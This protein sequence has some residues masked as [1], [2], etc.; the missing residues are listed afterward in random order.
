MSND[1]NR[2]DFLKR[3]V[4]G[5]AIIAAS[6]LP[7]IAEDRPELFPNRGGYERLA[8][9][10]ATVHIGLPKPFSILHI[11]DSHLTAA[12]P[13]ES[14]RMQRRHKSRTAT[15]G[16]R[17]EE[18]LRDSLAWARDHVDYIVYTGDLIDWQTE[19]N[20]D[21]VRKYFGDNMFGAIGN[22][23]HW[24]EEWLTDPSEQDKAEFREANHRALSEVYPFDVECHAQ[25]IGGVNFIAMDNAFG[26]FATR[27]VE[28]FKAEAAKGFPMVLCMHVPL[29]SDDIWRASDRFW[30]EGNMTVDPSRLGDEYR[31]QRED[32]VTR[33]FIA[34]LRQEPLLRAL[35]TGHEHFALDDP[36][37]PTAMQYVV[38]GNFLFTG[39]EVMFV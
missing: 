13:H 4:A 15:F 7:V 19:A 37:S 17:Q 20:Y 8:L 9:S 3:M 21:L 16:G 36:F 1:I 14:E 26:T 38:G 25:Q 22:H 29:Y 18:A 39:R 34:Y 2:R 31:A 5:G 24:S 32:P 27:Q 6:S 23:E 11:S 12:Y 28:F 10:Y 30:N 33:D 35:L